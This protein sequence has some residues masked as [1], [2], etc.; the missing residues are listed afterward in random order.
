MFNRKLK[1]DLA[2][3]RGKATSFAEDTTKLTRQLHEIDLQ[4]FQ[5]SQKSSWAEM[6]PIFANLMI[7]VNYRRAQENE[8]ISNIM[9]PEL[10]KTYGRT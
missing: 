9:I 6:Q 10:E 1:E 8:R 3:W 5:M 2:Y 4:L 7:A